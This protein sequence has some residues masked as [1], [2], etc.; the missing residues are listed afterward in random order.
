MIEE[1]D[2]SPRISET[3]FGTG[4]TSMRQSGPNGWHREVGLE[5]WKAGKC[6]WAS[7]FINVYE[8]EADWRLLDKTLAAM[9]GLYLRTID[10]CRT[11]EMR[12]IH[13]DV[14]GAEERHRPVDKPVGNSERHYGAVRSGRCK[15][16][17]NISDVKAS[18]RRGDG[19]AK[20][21]PRLHTL[22]HA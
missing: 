4:S 19:V 3:E 12:P 17:E 9:I 10:K 2:A 7:C 21:M 6:A 22:N 18:V 5:G 20:C 16:G 8:F 11:K 15:T 14:E 13:N 1:I